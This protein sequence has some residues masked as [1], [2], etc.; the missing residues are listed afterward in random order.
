MEDSDEEEEEEEI[1]T[2]MVPT[3]PDHPPPG[4]S[5]PPW[6]DDHYHR[7]KGP[8]AP[9]IFFDTFLDTPLLRKNTILTKDVR[10]II[11]CVKITSQDAC[12]K[13]HRPDSSRGIGNPLRCVLER[14]SQPY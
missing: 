5:R 8:D 14:S 7:Q 13:E 4:R 3:E 1:P 6:K 12:N 2:P 10:Q 9:Q 11:D